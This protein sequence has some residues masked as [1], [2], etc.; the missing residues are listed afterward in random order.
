MFTSWDFVRPRFWHPMSIMEQSLMDVES[1]IAAPSNKEDD[2]FFVDLPVNER[3]MAPAVKQPKTQQESTRAFSSYSYSNSSVVDDKGRRVTSTRRRYEDSTGRLKAVHEREM[4]GKKLKTVW[5]RKNEKDSGEHH[6]MC[7]QC[8]AD[9]FE[10]CWAETPFG[11]AQEEKTKELKS[12]G[13]GAGE[14]AAQPQGKHQEPTQSKT[15]PQEDTEVS[16]PATAP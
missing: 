3:G 15:T 2:D 6:T 9:E 7:S 10:R 16:E 8:T 12:Q 5:S 11:K 1:M 4:D 13:E 14:G